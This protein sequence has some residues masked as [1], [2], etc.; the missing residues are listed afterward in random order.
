MR[1]ILEMQGQLNIQMYLCDSA[2]IQ[3]IVI[4]FLSKWYRTEIWQN[5][6][7]YNLLASP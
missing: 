1:H 5:V 3:R 4:F 2:Y 6:S 7:I